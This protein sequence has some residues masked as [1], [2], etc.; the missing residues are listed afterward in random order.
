MLTNGDII[1]LMSDERL[2]EFLYTFL[3][4]IKPPYNDKDMI[5]HCLI[6]WLQENYNE[7]E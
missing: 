5:I 6:G 1:R 2:A 3:S 7:E 4:K